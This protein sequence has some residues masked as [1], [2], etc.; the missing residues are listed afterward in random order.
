VERTSVDVLDGAIRVR[1][2]N[3]D[4][5]IGLVVAC[6]LYDVSSVLIV[7]DFDRDFFVR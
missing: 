6:L 3:I 1:D 4:F 5:D 7:D 2:T